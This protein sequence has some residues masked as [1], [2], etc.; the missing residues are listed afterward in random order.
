MC[1]I[2]MLILNLSM[3]EHKGSGRRLIFGVLKARTPLVVCFNVGTFKWLASD[4]YFGIGCAWQ[5]FSG[6]NFLI[7][8]YYTITQPKLNE[9]RT[10]S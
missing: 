7:H 10:S 3:L 8:S 5:P 9:E 6:L 1:K 4:V 2:R